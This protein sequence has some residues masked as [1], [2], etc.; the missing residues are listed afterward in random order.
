MN[1]IYLIAI[2]CLMLP[3]LDSYALVNYL[4]FHKACYKVSYLLG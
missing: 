4:F 1:Q 3:T 2:C